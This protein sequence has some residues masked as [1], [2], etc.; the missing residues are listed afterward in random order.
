MGVH[1]TRQHWVT[2]RTATCN[3]LRGLLYVFGVVLRGGRK[4][5]LK[6]LG[7]Q[8]AQIDEQLPAIMRG[9]VDGQIRTLGQLQQRI[10]TLER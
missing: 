6:A 9:L 10:D 1:S 2:V 3:A 4:A 5:R 7:E 8:R